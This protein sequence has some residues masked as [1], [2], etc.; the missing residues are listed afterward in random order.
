[1]V[2]HP[3]RVHLFAC[4]NFRC[5]FKPSPDSAGSNLDLYVDTA[6]SLVWA[7]QVFVMLVMSPFDVRRRLFPLRR[8]GESRYRSHRARAY[9]STLYT[10]ARPSWCARPW[11]IL[12]LMLLCAMLLAA[13]SS[14]PPS[15]PS[16]SASKDLLRAWLA[17]T[18]DIHDRPLPD[19]VAL[20][21]VSP[22]IRPCPTLVSTSL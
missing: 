22:L 13:M 9:W 3:A 14:L 5:P 2:F 7:A 4:Y 6:A 15:G 20:L 19:T 10:L 1:M 12:A 8:A 11:G 17:S 16:S 18:L 21:T